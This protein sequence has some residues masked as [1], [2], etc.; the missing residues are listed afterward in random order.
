MKNIL[1]I[2]LLTLLASCASRP[3]QEEDTSA[4]TAE[5]YTPE[6]AGGFALKCLPDDSTR[7]IL[8]VYSPDTMRV[9]IPQGGFGSLACMSSTYVGMLRAAG[10]ADRIVAVSRRDLLTDADVSSRSVEI[11]YE[12]AMDYES[13]LASGAELTLIYGVGGESAIAG[14]LAE[15]GVPYIYITDFEEQDPLGRAEWMVALGA[16]AGQDARQ[17]FA[18]VAQAY[19]PAEGSVSV[20]VNAPYGGA[21]FM[22]GRSNYMSRLINDAGG[23]LTATQPEGVE[24]KPIDMEIAI[25]ALN[26]SAIWLNPGRVSS[27]EEAERL[28]PHASFRGSIWNQTSD[29]FESGAARPD[30]VLRELQLIFNGL[31]ADSLHYFHKL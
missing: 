16:L 23:R 31:Q 22:P 30:L 25:P 19:K 2:L 11:G 5:F 27:R 7:L 15:L 4:Y 6:Y 9:A 29:F 12:G 3:V 1:Y 26:S 28:V 14:K 8:E 13:L 20:M 17:K 21:W 18:A 10:G 24:S